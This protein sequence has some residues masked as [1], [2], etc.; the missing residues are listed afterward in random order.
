MMFRLILRFFN[1][2]ISR[3]FLGIFTGG[4]VA[5]DG[6]ASGLEEELVLRVPGRR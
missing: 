1:P 4:P 6:G 2:A 5:V 3:N